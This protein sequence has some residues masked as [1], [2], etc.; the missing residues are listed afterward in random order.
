MQQWQLGARL[1]LGGA[2][3]GERVWGGRELSAPSLGGEGSADV[4]GG[5]YLSKEEWLDG[6]V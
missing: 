4:K 5:A 1:W 2:N 6:A 3:S